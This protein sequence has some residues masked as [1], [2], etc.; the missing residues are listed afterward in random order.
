MG[1]TT[2]F[3]RP[4]DTVDELEHEL[5]TPLTSILSMTELLRDHPD[6]SE[7]ERRRFIEAILAEGERLTALVELLLRSGRLEAAALS[8]EAAPPAPG[9]H[10]A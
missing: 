1:R 2:A 3:D 4:V 10:P 7:G 9:R 5:R 6:M 8:R